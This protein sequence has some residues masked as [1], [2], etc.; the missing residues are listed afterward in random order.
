MATVKMIAERMNVSSATVSRSLRGGKGVKPETLAKIL[1]VAEEMG[2]YKSNS[3][4]GRTTKLIGLVVTTQPDGELFELAR[5]YL[6]VINHEFATRGWQ[7]HPVFVPCVDEK[8]EAVLSNFT[9]TGAVN[10]LKMDACLMIGSLSAALASKYHS[11]LVERFNGR[12]VMVCRHDIINGLSGV[13]PMD[14]VG[15]QQIAAK[16]L[17]SGHTRVGWIGSLGSVANA[18][19]RLSGVL[20][21]FRKSGGEVAP[22]LWLNDLDP[23]PIS[24]IEQNLKANLPEDRSEWPTA[25]ICST[26]W[27]AAKLIAWAHREGLRVP[28]DFSVMAFDN[29]KM[30]EELAEAVI[31]SIV[32]PYEQVARCAVELLEYQMDSREFTPVVWSLPPKLRE[33]ETVAPLKKKDS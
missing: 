19:E 15:G 9:E 22:Q 28:E 31:S 11:K 2:Y 14:Y 21:E 27:L 4:N 6:L 24:V 20:K 30:A 5:R 25:W 13:S 29:T 16:L 32:F 7:L 23:L 18:D 10:G 3:A 33:G 1:D 12:V 8:G 26:D 17:A